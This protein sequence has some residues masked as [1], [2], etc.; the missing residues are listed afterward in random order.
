[1]ESMG[2]GKGMYL[3]EG[4]GC[5]DGKR[6]PSRPDGRL[7]AVRLIEDLLLC[8]HEEFNRYNI[9]GRWMQIWGLAFQR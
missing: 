8:K 9:D 5:C 3:C 1:M 6:Q 2:R 7:L 4:G